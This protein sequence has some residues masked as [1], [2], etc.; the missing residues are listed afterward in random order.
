MWLVVVWVL[1]MVLVLVEEEEAVLA[2][3]FSFSTVSSKE[4]LLFKATS[5]EQP[6]RTRKTEMVCSRLRVV[7][8]ETD[9][10]I[11]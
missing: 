7:K 1:L 11:F 4:E 5:M 3:V 2:K 9:G 8:E 6:K 10:V